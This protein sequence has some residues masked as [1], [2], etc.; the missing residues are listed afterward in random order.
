[1]N[2]AKLR[3]HLY[4]KAIRWLAQH[5]P[6]SDPVPLANSIGVRMAAHLWDR[7]AHLVA[8]DVVHE[9]GRADP[10]ESP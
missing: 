6:E 8:R 2:A 10:L 4:L 1:M 7:P 9:R 5:E 3:S